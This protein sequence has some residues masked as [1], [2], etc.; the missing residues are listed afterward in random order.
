MHRRAIRVDDSSILISGALILDARGYS[1]RDFGV[2]DGRIYT[3]DNEADLKF[4]T[5]VIDASGCIVMPGLVDPHTHLRVPGGE[6]AETFVSGTKAGAVGGYCA[7]LAMPNTEPAVDLPARVL[8][9]RQM[10]KDLP[11][12]V[13]VS[14]TI[15]KN[16]AGIELSPFA[17]LASVGVKVFT[18][19][20]S[21]V[22]NPRLMLQ[23]LQYCS[24]LGLL[25]AQHCETEEL[26]NGGV[27]NGGAVADRLGLPAIPASSEE[28]MVSRDIEL[29]RSVDAAIHFLHL[30][31][32]RAADLVS[33]AKTDRL[34]VTAEVTPHHLFLDDSKLGDF[35]SRFKV[36]P[37]LRS[38]ADVS[39]LWE[40]LG[41]GTFDVIGT[42]HAPHPRWK[43]ETTIDQAAFGML[44]LQHALGVIF[45]GA[46]R[47]LKR[48]IVPKVVPNYVDES[49]GLLG[50]L[51]IEV[52]LLRWLWLVVSMMSWKPSQLIGY[53][54]GMSG[55]LEDGSRAT[56]VIFDPNGS[57]LVTT[58]SLHS[59]AKN[60]PYL[61]EVLDGSIREVFVSG[62]HLVKDGELIEKGNW[63]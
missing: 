61:D 8:M 59:K 43:K 53:E 30:S 57:L 3:I 16:R 39:G 11:V 20:G 17:G 22:Q 24:D 29:A 1:K 54:P 21:G 60:S 47:A 63:N 44:G 35:D 48:G 25:I 42:D 5:Q 41:A 2:K 19:D 56:F 26:F 62:K 36:N 31:T 14:G 40:H 52:D 10:I 58:A 55:L 28:V 34:R 9:I 4:K 18:D 6:E 37:P 38:E 23:A 45:T 51:P 46:R 50:D 33:R 13:L 7:L 32:K 27:M 49:I 12:D 15:T